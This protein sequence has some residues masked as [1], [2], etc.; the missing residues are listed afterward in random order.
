MTPAPNLFARLHKW[1]RRQDENYLTES[2]A[3][4]LE[5]LLVLAPAVGVRLVARLTGGLIDL[6]ATEAGAVQVGTQV[7]AGGGRV[8]LQ[9]RAP[10]RL[11]WVEVKAESPLRPGQL[12]GYLVLLRGSDVEQTRLVLL[13][14]HPERYAPGDAVPDR[15]FRWFEVADWL[16]DEAAAA[17]AAGAVPGFVVRQYID[18]Q[19]ERGMTLVHV[20]KYM[21]EG[22]R[23]AS[24]LM[25]ML[26]EAAAAC[27]V[28]FQK[29]SG[30]DALGVTLD[31]GK[32]WVG[33]KCSEPEKLW[34]GT[35]ARI[36]TEAGGRLPGW[37]VLPPGGEFTAWRG[38]ELDSPA[39]HFYSRSKVEQM[40]WLEDFIR[41]SL[42]LARAVETPD[43]PPPPD[44]PA[45]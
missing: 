3:V 38:E 18:F 40:E 16:A 44:D 30:W 29:G 5:H 26:T 14:R 32:Y 31:R 10:L 22:L 15:E 1:A 4:V 41:V 21:P 36:H 8:D 37:E 39:V 6:P 27:R 35:K 20:G 45:D 11:V 17:D 34:F 9:L 43:Q 2:L 28:P 23:A 19:E 24:H 7:E 13:T 25:T 42:E 12:E 33:V